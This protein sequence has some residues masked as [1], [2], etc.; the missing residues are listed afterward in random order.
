LHR[1]KRKHLNESIRN[2]MSPFVLADAE[3]VKNGVK[4]LRNDLANREWDNKH[5]QIRHQCYFDAG[6]RFLRFISN[7]NMI[8]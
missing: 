6:Y 7:E 1:C 8:K 4:R 3:A 5:G 2:S